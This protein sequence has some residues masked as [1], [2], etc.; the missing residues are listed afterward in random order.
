MSAKTSR[1]SKSYILVRTPRAQPEEGV[2]RR[3]AAG[4]RERVERVVAFEKVE[5]VEE[6]GGEETA[7][8]RDER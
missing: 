4:Q 8:P 1:P 7:E 5:N 6:A 3:A 2:Y